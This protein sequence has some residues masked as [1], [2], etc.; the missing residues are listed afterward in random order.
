MMSFAGEL[1]HQLSRTANLLF[2][3]FA[4]TVALEMW[5]LSVVGLLSTLTIT[6]VIVVTLISVLVSWI[7]TI[8]YKDKIEVYQ[9]WPILIVA[10]IQF[11]STFYIS[12]APPAMWDEFAYTVAL[13]KLYAEANHFF[14]ASNYGPYSAFPQNF[15]AITTASILIF[16]D[17]IISKLLNYCFSA[18]LML[19]AGYLAFLS[20]VSR[21]LSL[22]AGALVG[23]SSELIAFV[24]VVKNDIANSFFQVFS[25]LILVLYIKNKKLSYSV[26]I[27]VFLGTAVGI[28]YNSLIPAFSIGTVFLWLTWSDGMK[29]SDKYIRFFVFSL[30]LIIF[31]APWYLKN[32]IEFGNPIFPIANELWGGHNDFHSGYSAIWHEAL[33]GDINFSWINGT[34]K[35]FLLKFADGF[36]YLLLTLGILGAVRVVIFHRNK[37]EMYI[38]ILLL[39][40]LL[41]TLRFGFWEPRYTYVLLILLSVLAVNFINFFV[42]LN[43]NINSNL[44]FSGILLGLLCFLA[45]YGKSK[46]EAIYGE[47]VSFLKEQPREAFLQKYVAFWSVANWL[48]QNTP[49]DARIAIW[50]PQIFYYLNRPYFHIHPLTEKGDLVHKLAGNDYYQF[51]LDEKIDYICLSNMRYDT[52]PDRI[53]HI[54]DFFKQ[55][56][57]SIDELVNNGKLEKIAVVDNTNIYRLKKISN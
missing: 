56:N 55:L 6:A 49:T 51:F 46:G 26:L 18:G 43:E 7:G 22:L 52:I 39:S 1:K 42:K 19:L 40:I 24:P 12:F 20:G 23:I 29:L 45:L 10:I 9:L 16:S 15:E 27:G 33:Y 5:L 35:G 36:G 32:W 17:P 31:A 3:F 28:K 21:K 38:A 44:L 8:F 13:P 25:I 14:Y 11:S 54:K 34:I 30:S 2:I 37:E 47:K 57:Y 48:N 41:L 4:I 50:G 53:P